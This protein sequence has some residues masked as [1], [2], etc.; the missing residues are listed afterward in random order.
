MTIGSRPVPVLL[1]SDRAVA[2]ADLERPADRLGEQRVDR[3]RVG[4]RRRRSART[5]RC[6]CRSR[7]RPGPGC[8][9]ASGG[10]RA[11]KPVIDGSSRPWTWTSA[12]GARRRRA[13]R[14]RPSSGACPRARRACR[15][16][17]AAW[18]SARSPTR[19]AAS[20]RPATCGPARD[21]QRRRDRRP[22]RRAASVT[23]S[24]VMA[25]LRDERAVVAAGRRVGIGV[26]GVARR[27]GR[28]E[29][30][31]VAVEVRSAAPHVLDR[32]VRREQAADVAARDRRGRRR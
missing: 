23:A 27:P 17:A 7:S 8:P 13:A 2:V 15:R 12:G 32:L 30:D 29:R 10:R 5:G 16:C 3:D 20:R 1:A 31:H 22:C 9:A 21:D 19:G 28:G 14:R 11:T 6:R 25:R 18:G 4:R 26:R 24:V